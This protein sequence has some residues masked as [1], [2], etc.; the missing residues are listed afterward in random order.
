MNR[1]ELEE[2]IA[3]IQLSQEQLKGQ[4]STLQGHLDEAKHWLDKL[5]KLEEE[6]AQAQAL[7]PAPEGNDD[8]AEQTT[9]PEECASEPCEDAEAA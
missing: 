9:A 2:R 8:A 7:E 1:A 3:Q 6:Q 4:F 5:I